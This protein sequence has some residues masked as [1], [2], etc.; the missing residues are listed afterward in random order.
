MIAKTIR[1][2]LLNHTE[3]TGATRQIKQDKLD[4]VITQLFTDAG[5]GTVNAAYF[6]DAAAF[7]KFNTETLGFI[8]AQ[9]DFKGLEQKGERK[10]PQ[11]IARKYQVSFT[12]GNSNWVFILSADEKIIAIN[13][14]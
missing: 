11:S 13:H 9:G 1:D 4:S 5:K 6:K 3:K 12:K 2:I 7:A 8:Q 14:M 10:N